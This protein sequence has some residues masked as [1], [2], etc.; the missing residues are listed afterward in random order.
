MLRAIAVNPR[1]EPSIQNESSQHPSPA[2]PHSRSDSR[3]GRTPV[4]AQLRSLCRVARVA[5]HDLDM[6]LLLREVDVGRG[7]RLQ[8]TRRWI[9][10]PDVRRRFG[11]DV[12]VHQRQRAVVGNARASLA[13]HGSFG[14]LGVHGLET[15]EIIER[16]RRRSCRSLERLPPRDENHRD[17]RPPN[18]YGT[19]RRSRRHLPRPLKEVPHRGQYA[20]SVP[21]APGN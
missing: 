11:V 19:D 6:V 3:P 14:V 2:S 4:T 12:D 9:E 17:D 13:E 8:L 18:P 21:H 1:Y 10:A 15:R 7:R 16:D 5:D 20:L